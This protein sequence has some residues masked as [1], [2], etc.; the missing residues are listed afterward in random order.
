MNVVNVLNAIRTNASAEYQSRIPAATKE[1]FNTISQQINSY[2]VLQN[3]F[4]NVLCNKIGATYV[5]NKLLN[6]PL[7]IL[8]TGAMPLGLTKEEI[9]TN[10]AKDMGKSEGKKL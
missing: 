1:N 3:E 5:H 10:V 9:Y 6:N 4:I 8:K 7:S 2:K